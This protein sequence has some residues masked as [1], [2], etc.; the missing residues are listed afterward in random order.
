MFFMRFM[1]KNQAF[2]EIIT[3]NVKGPKGGPKRPRNGHRAEAAGDETR[4]PYWGLM[5]SGIVMPCSS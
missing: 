1:V 3:L 5:A 4:K 2:H